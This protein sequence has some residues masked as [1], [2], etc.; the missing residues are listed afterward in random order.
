MRIAVAVLFILFIAALNVTAVVAGKSVKPIGRSLAKLEIGMIVPL[1]G[2]LIITLT[3]RYHYSMWGYYIYFVGMDIAVY[4]VLVFTMDYFEM[5]WPFKALKFFVWSLIAADGIQYFLNPTYHH[6]FALQAIKIDG[7]NYYLLVSLSGQTYHRI[8]CYGIFFIALVLSIIKTVRSPKI[9]RERYL[10]VSIAMIMACML[11][12]F[13]IF[14]R[15]PMDLSM[16]A[17]GIYGLLVFYLALYYRPLK[18]LDRMLANIASEL[19]EALF[20][21]DVSGKCIWANEPALEMTGLKTEDYEHAHKNLISLFGDIYSNGE[22]WSLKKTYPDRSTKYYNFELRT[23]ADDKGK[24]T[25]TFLRIR[26]NTDEQLAMQREIYS[27]THDSL[28]GLYTKEYLYELISKTLSEPQTC[29]YY[30]IFVDVNNFK[31]VNDVFGTDF[32]DYALKYIAKW[33]A[34]SSKPTWIYGRLGGDT[35]GGLVPVEDFDSER[36]ERELSAFDIKDRTKEHRLLIHFGVYEVTEENL[37]VSVMF[38]RAHLA[39]NRIKDDYNVHIAYYD[40]KI[41]NGVVMDQLL[42]A[43][44]SDAIE[45]RQIVPYL[46]PIVDNKGRVLGA[47]ALARW[48]HPT[49]GFMSPDRFIPVLERNGMIADVDLHIWRCS[50]EIL[51][52]WQERNV[53]MFISINISPKDFYFMNVPD[54]LIGLINEFGI[55][56]SRLRIEITETVMIG[57]VDNRMEDINRLRKFGFIIEMDDFG[58]GYSSLNLLQDMPVDVLKIDMAFL[59]K[60]EDNPKAEMILYNI[61]AM[62]KDLEITSLTEGVESQYQFEQL[63]RMGCKLFQGYH[64]SKPIPVEEFE[65]YCNLEEAV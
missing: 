12:T 61:I 15:T 7:Y 27:A 29:K 1:I 35:F 34:E 60:A 39:I 33:I 48:H 57:D 30:V 18:V 45:T 9:Y 36:V 16:T 65:R 37:E 51:K 38:D 14:S 3:G 55:K 6:A 17:F 31:I 56:P 41:R 13:Y 47:E 50:C 52:R 32:G 62:A 5:K 53:D 25:G 8:I 4:R 40:E 42:A 49:E 20:F 44:L 54:K 2:N 23:M 59:R 28:T 46:Q 19:N 26:D 63:S 21:Y 43:Q 11:E 24:E 58:S 22:S 64:F 10:V